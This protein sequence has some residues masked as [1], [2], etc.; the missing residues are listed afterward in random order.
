MYCT[1]MKLVPFPLSPSLLRFNSSHTHT[2]REDR[3]ADRVSKSAHSDGTPYN[4]Q[5]EEE[6]R[7]RD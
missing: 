4:W 6:E 5:G 3:Q 1:A 2:H 7:E